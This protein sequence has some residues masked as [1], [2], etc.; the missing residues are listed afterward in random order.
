VDQKL[1]QQI[2]PGLMAVFQQAD[3]WYTGAKTR[4]SKLDYDDLELKSLQLLKNFPSVKLYWQDQVKALLVDE[5]Q[6][7]NH[8]QRELVALLNGEN[9]NLFIVGDGKQSIYRFRGADICTS[10]NPSG[11]TSWREL[12]ASKFISCA[13]WF[14]TKSK[15]FA[16]TRF[17]RKGEYTLYR[18]ILSPT[19]R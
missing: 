3:E 15:R 16:K 17:R 19:A 10:P 18:A 2:I 12:P 9:K 4:L 13:S 14:A 11:S 6:D 8:R 1:A 5:F 7:T